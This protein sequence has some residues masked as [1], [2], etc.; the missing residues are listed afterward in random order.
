MVKVLAL[1]VFHKTPSAT[2]ELA[3]AFELS[4]FGFFQR[5][6]IQVETYISLFARGCIVFSTVEC[7]LLTACAGIHEV[8][9]QNMRPKEHEPDGAGEALKF[10]FCPELALILF[11]FYSWNMSRIHR[12]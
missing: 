5:G 1:S 3:S 11:Y 6:T 2:T 7:P 4:Q 12:K 8:F 10:I 9:L